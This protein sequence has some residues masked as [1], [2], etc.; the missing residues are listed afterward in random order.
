MLDEAALA[1]IEA[2]L[3][4]PIREISP[5]SPGRNN[6]VARVVLES[7]S[8]LAKRYFRHEG[9]RRDRLGT[10]FGML[11]FLWRNGI[12]TVPEPLAA[13]PEAGVGIYELV[14][15]RRLQPG[16]VTLDDGLQLA[17]LLGR[18]SDLRGE[19][20]AAELPVA[21][22]AAFTLEAYL[23]G[24]DA[25]LNRLRAGDPAV[26]P[27]IEDEVAPVLAAAREALAGAD[28]AAETPWRTPSPG[29]IGFHNA[30]RRPDGSLVFVDFEYAGWDDAAHVI[31][32]AC[33]PPD[34]PLPERFH[35]DVVEALVERLG[36]DDGLAE[37]VRL[38]FPLLALKWSLILLNEFAPV[39]RERR[40]YAGALPDG[41]ADEQI[42]RSRR[43]LE[44][45]RRLA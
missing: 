5:V 42:E 24:L 43:Q 13:A 6:V 12:R 23:D 40:S 34:V 45:A 19:P 11:T 1:A 35:S 8:V 9:D 17:D 26:R 39:A 32:S 18:M 21:S 15:A 16:E 31:A 44:V 25:R 29:D 14:D 36:A 30:L 20:G 41:F 38:V 4:E 33:L 27:F 2:A 28:L 3:G 37:R 22:D 7:R 10:E